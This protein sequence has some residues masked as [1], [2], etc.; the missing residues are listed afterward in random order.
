MTT[1]P[2]TCPPTLTPPWFPLWSDDDICQPNRRWQSVQALWVPGTLRPQFSHS[3]MVHPSLG[4]KA[5][6]TAARNLGLRDLRANCAANI[7][8]VVSKSAQHRRRCPFAPAC[9]STTIEVMSS[10]RITRHQ[11]TRTPAER[12]GGPSSSAAGS[13]DPGLPAYCALP[14]CRT[15]YRQFVAVGRAQ[16]FCSEECRRNAQNEQRRARSKLRHLEGLVEQARIDLAAFGCDDDSARSAEDPRQ[17]ATLG[18][19]RAAGVMA[20]LKDSDDKAAREFV[21]LYESVAPCFEQP[22]QLNVA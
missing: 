18:L 5:P 7:P 14:G 6:A 20:F 17:R 9:F 10:A 3:V 21:A 19:A 16:R 11:S 15:E 22:G 12:G 4:P 1:L 8:R 13:T 2:P